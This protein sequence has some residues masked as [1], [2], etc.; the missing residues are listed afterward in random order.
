MISCQP[1]NRTLCTEALLRLNHDHQ[2][3]HQEPNHDHHHHHHTALIIP[4]G[5]HIQRCGQ[6]ELSRCNH[7]TNSFS[8]YDEEYDYERSEFTPLSSSSSNSHVN[9]D[10]QYLDI[11][12]DRNQ[13]TSCNCETLE[14]ECLPIKVSLK[15]FAVAVMQVRTAINPHIFCFILIYQTDTSKTLT[16]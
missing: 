6:Q 16:Y 10:D 8:N 11:L 12:N 15:T 9:Y 5:I 1:Q 3:Q 7:Y 4:R 2:Q 14:E 13:Y